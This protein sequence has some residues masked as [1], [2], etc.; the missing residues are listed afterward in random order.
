MSWPLTAQAGEIAKAHTLAVNANTIAGAV[1]TLAAEF[2]AV[3]ALESSIAHANAVYALA[4]AVAIGK[5]ALIYG[6]FAFG[7]VPAKVTLTFAT[8]VET[9]AAA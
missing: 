6:Q 9:I 5:L 4:V 7:S 8:L 1:R 3:L 2:V